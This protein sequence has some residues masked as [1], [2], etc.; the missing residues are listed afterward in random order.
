MCSTLAGAASRNKNKIM[1]MFLVVAG[2]LMT[3]ASIYGVV[4]YNNK[5]H[6]KEFKELYKKEE[7]KSVVQPVKEET[8]LPVLGTVTKDPVKTEAEVTVADDAQKPKPVIKKKKREFS[9]REFSR[10]PLREK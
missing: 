2:V 9:I 1:K 10:A 8:E 5:I 3:S 7:T 4:D 6:T